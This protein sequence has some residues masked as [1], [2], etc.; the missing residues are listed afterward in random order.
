MTWAVLFDHPGK[1]PW[2]VSWIISAPWAHPVWHQYGLYL[3]DLTS[4]HKDGPPTIHAPGATH[5]FLL[6]ALDPAKPVP[7]NAETAAGAQWL[8]PPNY[9]Y[10]FKAESDLVARQRLQ[11]VVDRIVAK[12]ISPDTDFRQTWNDHLFPDAYALVH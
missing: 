7:R 12:E 5:E 4:P 2:G 10:Q 9:G 3:Y 8:Q 11:K 6:Y 1:V